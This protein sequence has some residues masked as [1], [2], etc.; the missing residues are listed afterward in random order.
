MT[1]GSMALQAA[2]AEH[3]GRE[4]GV[5]VGEGVGVAGL[6]ARAAGNLVRT[7]L[8]ESVAVGVAV[9]LALA[10]KRPVVEL[11]DASGLARAAEALA[12]AGALPGRSEGAF[13]AP[14]VVLAPLAVEADLPA[15][16]AG[17]GLAVAASAADAVG[18]L[19]AA[20]AA[21]GPTVLLVSASALAARD[22]GPAAGLGVPVLLR[23]GRGAV[24]LAEGEGVAL[25]LAAGGDAAV[26]D[27]RGCRD[28]AAIG[29]LVAPTGRVVVVAHEGASTLLAVLAG[30]F[31]RLESQPSFV[32]PRE[33]A[34]ALAAAIAVA[35]T[36]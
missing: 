11:L 1:S 13:A 33:G 31:W 28:V 35:L 18:L 4:G 29:T 16:P 14:V 6:A 22:S 27:L 23:E 19:A 21:R 20:L 12:D 3:A 26:V 10:G 24:L 32:H 30:A 9:G 15:L 2:L 34:T 5:L 17:I 36:P 8:S 25:A 7:P